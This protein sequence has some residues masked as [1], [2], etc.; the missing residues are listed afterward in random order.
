MIEK[1][2]LVFDLQDP[3][4]ESFAEECIAVYRANTTPEQRARNTENIK[5]MMQ[6]WENKFYTFP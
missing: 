4:N 1:K 6:R 5:I 2:R 3:L